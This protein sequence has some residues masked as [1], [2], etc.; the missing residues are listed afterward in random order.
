MIPLDL[1]R[2]LDLT[3]PLGVEEVVE[4]AGVGKEARV[5]LGGI[6]LGWFYKE[7]ERSKVWGD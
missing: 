6:L 3:E 2:L 5:R 1:R 7:D 4:F